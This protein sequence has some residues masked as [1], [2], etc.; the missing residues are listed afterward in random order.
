MTPYVMGDIS[1]EEYELFLEIRVAVREMPD[2]DLGKD[3]HGRAVEIS[4]HMITRALAEIFPN[5][6]NV[7]DGHAL[8]GW[9]HSWVVF[10]NNPHL[11]IDPYPIAMVEGPIMVFAMHCTPWGTFYKE[12]RKIHRFDQEPFLSH[13]KKITEIVKQ[14]VF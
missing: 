9:Q 13:V 10:K 14:S 2:I 6:F 5:N 8:K 11:I 1:K 12:G 7:K 3:N 4:C